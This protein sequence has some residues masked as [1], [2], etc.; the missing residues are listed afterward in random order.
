MPFL[1]KLR[2]PKEPPV[3]RDEMEM[4]A[5]QSVLAGGLADEYV[6]EDRTQGA[7]TSTIAACGMPNDLGEDDP[8]GSN[9]FGGGASSPFF[10]G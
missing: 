5:Y 4:G 2:R 1:S 9:P 8:F 10:G 6:F 7:A 3:S